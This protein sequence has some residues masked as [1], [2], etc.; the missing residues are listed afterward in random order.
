MVNEFLTQK[1]DFTGLLICTTNMRQLMD[2]AMQRRFHIM[3]EFKALNKS[4]IEKLFYNYFGSFKFTNRQIEVLEQYHSVT[5]GDFASLYGRI[6]FIP[7]AKIN[8]EYIINELIKMQEEKNEDR[9]IE[10]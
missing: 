3:T 1:E 5:P 10:F 8:S 2:P 4:G 7:Q 6:R 9:S